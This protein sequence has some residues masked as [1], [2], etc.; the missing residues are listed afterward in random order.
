MFIF[1]DGDED[2]W[3][4]NNMGKSEKTTDKIKA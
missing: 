3:P 2:F 4:L 1:K